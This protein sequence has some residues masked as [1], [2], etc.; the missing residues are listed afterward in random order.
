M[1][2][3]SGRTYAVPLNS[4]LEIVS[5]EPTR[6]ADHRAARGLELRGA[7]AALRP[8]GAP[9]PARRSSRASRT[10]VVVVGLAQQRLGLAVDELVGQQDIVIKPLGGS[11]P[12]RAR[13]VGR[14]RAGRPPHGAGAR[15]GGADGG[16]APPGRR[17]T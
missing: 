13:R 16:A 9:V 12:A 7:D 17:L 8:A 15:R 14:D 5:V 4:V 6:A 3:V 11:A 1:V 10:F 2:S